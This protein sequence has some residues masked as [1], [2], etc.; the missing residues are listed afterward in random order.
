MLVEELALHGND[1][2]APQW[3]QGR[4]R[5]RTGRS[6]WPSSAPGC[7]GIIAAYRLQAGR[8]RLHDLREERRRR[9]H[10]AGE[11]LSGLPGRRP[12]PL[13]QLLVRPARRLAVLLLTAGRAA[14]LLPPV[15][16]RVRHP[17]P[18]RASTPRSRRWSTTRASGRWT[19]R[20]RRPGRRVDVHGQRGDQRRRPAEPAAVPEDRGPRQRSPARRSTPPSGT[21]TSTSPASGSA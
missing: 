3:R 7:R 18:H 17:R 4:A 20:A 15:R 5:R 13:L 2:R 10:V 9:R 21:T 14:P 11:H 6:T 8:H 16:R 1:L 19:L 12:Q